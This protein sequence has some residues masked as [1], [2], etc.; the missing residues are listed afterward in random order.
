M[1]CGGKGAELRVTICINK[2]D[3]V[4][5][6]ETYCFDLLS[7]LAAGG[8][9]ASVFTLTSAPQT[10]ARVASTGAKLYTYPL[11]PMQA[12]DR[13]IVM[14][15]LASTLLLRRI[16]KQVPTLAIIHSPWPDEYPVRLP[17]ID[18][19][20]A[21]SP[22][23]ADLLQTRHRVR[24]EDIGV[25]PNGVDTSYFDAPPLGNR[26]GP[27]RVLWGSG[28]TRTDTTHSSRL[29]KACSRGTIYA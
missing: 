10:A 19:F 18:R 1:S 28:T 20:I 24:P 4:T 7:E 2:L 23:I 21:V 25:I 15:P 27:V 11:Y 26:K 14:H 5:G 22:Y 29:S 3:D 17:R 6:T 16:D 13:A 12:P 8:H 9:D